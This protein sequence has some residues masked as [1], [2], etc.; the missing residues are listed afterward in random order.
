MSARALTSEFQ[1]AWCL[2]ICP[3]I[4][5][6]IA[7]AGPVGSSLRPRTTYVPVRKS[8]VKVVGGAGRHSKSHQREVLRHA[9]WGNDTCAVAWGAQ[10]WCTRA[11]PGDGRSG[12]RQLPGVVDEH[13]AAAAGGFVPVGASGR[14]AGRG[15]SGRA[16][17]S[18]RSRSMR[19]PRA[20]RSDG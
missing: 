15:V 6:R 12:Q 5:P 17:G 16:G 20:A 1:T 14:G 7:G 10:R 18:P 3:R 19:L 9:L 13:G 4:S 8:R 2:C 11:S